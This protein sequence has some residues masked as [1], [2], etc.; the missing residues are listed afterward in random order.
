VVRRLVLP[1]LALAAACAVVAGLPRAARANGRLP[2][3]SSITF[4]QGHDNDV[5]AGLTFGLVLS[6]DG[7]KSWAWMCDDAIGINS[8]PYDPTYVYTPAGTVLATTLGGL[9]AMRD[10]CT[11]GPTPEGKNFVST[12]ALGPDGAFYFGAAQTA[13][14]AHG[15]P[16]DFDIYRS[17]DDGA[18]FPVTSQAAATGD[19]NV[20][21]QSIMVAPSS[22]QVVY[23]SGFR[24]VPTSGAMREHLLFRSD[25]GGTSWGSNLVTGTSGLVVMPNS[26][27]HI[28]AIARD[29]PNHVYARVE[30]IDNMTTDALYVSDD[31]GAHWT[32]IHRQADR[33]VAFIARAPG[34]SGK[35]DLIAATARF[36]PE[37]SH[38]DGTTWTPLAGAPHITCLTENAAGELW[39][40]TQNYG[41]APAPSDD[42]GSM[43]TTD[44]ATWT[45]VLRYQDLTEAVSGCGAETPQQK[46]CAAMWCGVCAQLG[47]Q[48]SPSYACPS[49]SEAPTTTPTRGGCCDTGA[50]GG[51]A[52][53]LALVVATF[54]VRPR[55]RPRR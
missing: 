2:A 21:W 38:D 1:S 32:E 10:G 30:Y 27:I 49:A 28:V 26:V 53:A 11:F 33:F 43:K 37:I 51:G 19:T 22:P 31:S 17:N 54:V 44:L 6:H 34:P 50:S 16:K 47:C 5:V 20:W 25:N 39:A 18:T 36:G 40:C 12:A 23:L 48:P 45:R 52:L 3:T 55:R 7:G 14:A 4:R 46:S 8:G 9:A 35:R 42:A 41:V 13:D 29:K 24:Y 15:L